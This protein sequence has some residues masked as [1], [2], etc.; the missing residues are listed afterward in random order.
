[1]LAS[2]AVH[3]SLAGTN[4]QPVP[5]AFDLVLICRSRLVMRLEVVRLLR[6]CLGHIISFWAAVFQRQRLALEK[7]PE[8]V[9]L[10]RN[11]LRKQGR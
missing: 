11:S 1:M 6:E 4:E 7:N 3:E 2:P 9:Q 5:T 10:S 8:R